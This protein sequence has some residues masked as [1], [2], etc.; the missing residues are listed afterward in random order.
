MYGSGPY[1]AFPPEESVSI[2][3]YVV[4]SKLLL[5]VCAVSLFGY[6]FLARKP[7]HIDRKELVPLVTLESPSSQTVYE[8][9]LF[10]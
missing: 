7:Q 1:D 8:K 6:Y 3:D 10:V 2:S 5:F 9:D 4:V